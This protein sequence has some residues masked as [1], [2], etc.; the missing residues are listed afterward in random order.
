M[1]EGFSEAHL[2]FPLKHIALTYLTPCISL[3]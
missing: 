3:V 2:E 1:E